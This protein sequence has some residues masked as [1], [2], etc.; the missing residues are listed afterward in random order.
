MK[1]KLGYFVDSDEHAGPDLL[2]A[3]TR[4]KKSLLDKLSGWSVQVDVE[5]VHENTRD[6]GDEGFDLLALN[7]YWQL[8]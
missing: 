7:R 5:R 4:A 8:E 6:G 3:F 2:D 1:W